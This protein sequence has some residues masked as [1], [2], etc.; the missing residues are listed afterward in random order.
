MTFYFCDTNVIVKYYVTEPGSQ[1]ARQLLDSGE[2]IFLVEITI[3]EVAAA[4]SIL[5]RV[6]QLSKS[7]REQLWERFERDCVRRYRFLSVTSQVIRTAAS[8]C[9][10]HP[11]KGY[12]AV[13]V[14]AALCLQQMLRIDHS[15]VFVS[16]DRTVTA[17]AQAEGLR[18]DNPF[19][20]VA[21][22]ER[23][24]IPH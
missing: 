11:L 12:D 1:W 22:N 23:E 18:V 24:L 7:H 20:H 10:N 15:L 17:A 19:W 16:G 8:L 14:A 13:Q 5:Q 2:P 4:L 9:A 6:A 3:V 21:E